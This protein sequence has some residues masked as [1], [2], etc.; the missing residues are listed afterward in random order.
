MSYSTSNPPK[1]MV[2][3]MGGDSALW[4]YKSTD[5][6]TSA[7]ATSYFTDGVALGMRQDDVVIGILGSTAGR[8]HALG[9]VSAVVASSG[10]TVAWG[11]LTSTI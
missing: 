2:P 9:V 6:S 1:L 5:G 11:N 3:G 7:S 10:A 4:I 8:V